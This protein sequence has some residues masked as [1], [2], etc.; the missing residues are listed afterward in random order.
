MQTFDQA[1][2]R[3][4]QAGRVSMQDALRVATSPHDFKL[5]VA[6][7]GRTSTSMDDLGDAVKRGEG[8]RT[9]N[10]PPPAPEPASTRPRLGVSAAPPGV[11]A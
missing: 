4:Y 5:L 8:V 11:A 1:L 6:G 3:H 9:A 7:D 2:L 10:T